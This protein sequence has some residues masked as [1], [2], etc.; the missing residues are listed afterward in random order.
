MRTSLCFIN[1]SLP[2]LNRW[3]GGGQEVLRADKGQNID[4]V[5]MQEF[6]SFVR[7]LMVQEYL[8]YP[9]STLIHEV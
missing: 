4:F 9:K 1:F 8:L 6:C 7:V 2:K 3:G 5:E